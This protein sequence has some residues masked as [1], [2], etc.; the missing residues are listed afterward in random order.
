MDEVGGAAPAE[1]LESM[2]PLP[3]AQH[4]TRRRGQTRSLPARDDEYAVRRNCNEGPAIIQRRIG[5]RYGA[6]TWRA[7]AAAIAISVSRVKTEM[8][9]TNSDWSSQGSATPAVRPNA[10]SRA[11]SV[12]NGVYTSL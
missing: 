12:Q 3:H 2:E 11:P 6:P 9:R 5:P 7:S 4:R 10:P 1:E 8:A